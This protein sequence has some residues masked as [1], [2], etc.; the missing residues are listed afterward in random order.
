MRV[1]GVQPTEPTVTRWVAPTSPAGQP[2]CVVTARFT[3]RW[4][5]ASYVS[6]TVF[7]QVTSKH[8]DAVSFDFFL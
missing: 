1:S 6:S 7:D 5:S 4:I 3:D 2:V 8:L